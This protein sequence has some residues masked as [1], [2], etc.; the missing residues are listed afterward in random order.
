MVHKKKKKKG[1]ALRRE[2]KQTTENLRISAE[3]TRKA[4]G[5]V[6]GLS[7]K[8]RLELA[9]ARARGAGLLDPKLEDGEITSKTREE[10]R[11]EE[12]T[13]IA[14]KGIDIETEKERIKAEQFEQTKVVEERE[15]IIA[16]LTENEAFAQEQAETFARIGGKKPLDEMALYQQFLLSIAV[17][18]GAKLPGQFSGPTAT[19]AAIQ[20][21]NLKQ[22]AVEKALQTGT[23]FKPIIGEAAKTYATN[24]KSIALTA[25]MLLNSK[26]TL[27]AVPIL[28][29]TIGTYP[30]A[31]FIKEEALQTLGF[32]TNA[33]KKAGD[34]EGEQTALDETKEVLNPGLW[35]TILSKIPIVNVLNSLK[36]FY[37]AARTKVKIDQDSLDS[38]R[39]ELSSPS[40]PNLLESTGKTEPVIPL[41]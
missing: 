22:T 21:G 23:Q 11:A 6:G 10:A 15:P 33:A 17:T 2:K 14:Q 13:N 18:G 37:K 8:D 12:I 40:P 25:K 38:R 7:D 19:E 24:G 39:G 9:T 5:R 31:G 41:L 4:R 1:Q 26:A 35:S 29:A 20:V 32:A 34:L 27:I 3:V 36:D 16:D 30:F 28:I